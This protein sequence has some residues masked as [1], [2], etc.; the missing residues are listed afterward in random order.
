[1][2]EPLSYFLLREYMIRIIPSY[3]HSEYDRTRPSYDDLKRTLARIKNWSEVVLQKDV[4]EVVRIYD[5]QAVRVYVANHYVANLPYV[6]S[7]LVN[8][9][10][11]LAAQDI[12]SLEAQVHF[13]GVDEETGQVDMWLQ[14]RVLSTD[15]DLIE[16]F[17]TMEFVPVDFYSKIIEE[18]ENADN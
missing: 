18:S 1:M 6:N 10:I 13:N 3:A 9:M 8:L 14:L 16:V 4:D 11:D 5:S 17:K 12:I 2:T 7:P 15:S